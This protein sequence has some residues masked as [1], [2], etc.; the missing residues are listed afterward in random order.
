M[1]RH[2]RPDQYKLLD[3]LAREDLTRVA[4]YVAN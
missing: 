4:A 2:P 3:S 1:D